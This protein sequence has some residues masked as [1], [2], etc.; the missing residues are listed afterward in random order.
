MY[1]LSLSAVFDLDGLSLHSRRLV[2]RYVWVASLIR[3]L[4]ILSDTFLIIYVI[5][6]VGYA[7]SGYLVGIM[8]I[9]QGLI[10]YPSGVFSDKIGQRWVLAIAFASYGVSF[11]LFTDAHSMI[12][13]T[14]AYLFFALASAQQ[15]GAMESWFDNNYRVLAED[16]NREIYKGIMAKFRTITDL[17]GALMLIT[18]GFLATYVS[19]KFVFQLQ[20]VGMMVLV[21]IVVVF[22]KDTDGAR[23]VD[24]MNY[25]RLFKEGIITITENRL[26]LLIV[27]A[28]VLYTSTLGVFGYLIMF[29]GYFG[30]TGS[31]FGASSFRFTLFISGSILLW[32]LADRFR[33][34]DPEKWLGPLSFFH[35][36]LFFGFTGFILYL[37]PI[38]NQ[39]NLTGIVLF[40]LLIAAGHTVRVAI[41]ILLQ[42]IYIDLIPNHR[43]NGFY[44][45]VP[46]LTLIVNAPLMW[47]SG[48]IIERYGYVP[49]TVILLLISVISSVFF[50]LASKR[51]STSDV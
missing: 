14:I 26:V 25:L 30:Y 33:K 15:S 38:T 31:D 22:I 32:L 19:R 29:P 9:T 39:F 18:G 8:L 51:I 12:E 40:G 47:V 3:S 6:N 17:I 5:D 1:V 10:D 49:V 46:T 28:V 23:E 34:I 13:F 50:Q 43:R 16:E 27:S 21:L 20:I 35:A 37:V 36:V 42:S 48:L 4:L 24:R 2:H 7:N 44:S 11:W 45:L 41:D